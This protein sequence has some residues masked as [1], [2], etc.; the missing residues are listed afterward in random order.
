M[1]VVRLVRISPPL[2]PFWMMEKMN[3]FR[4]SQLD[5]VWMMSISL[6]EGKACH[7]GCPT[8]ASSPL[9]LEAVL[10]LTISY[11]ETFKLF[12]YWLALKSW[13]STKAVGGCLNLLHPVAMGGEFDEVIVVQTVSLWRALPK[14]HRVLR[15]PREFSGCKCLSPPVSWPSK[16]ALALILQRRGVVSRVSFFAFNTVFIKRGSL[17]SSCFL[18]FR[19]SGPKYN[20]QKWSK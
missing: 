15:P 19:I 8:A 2:P 17:G 16:T 1:D 5:S 6:A 13:F 3:V 20:W 7:A 11:A 9:G 4:T 18:S 12:G 14:V 10:T